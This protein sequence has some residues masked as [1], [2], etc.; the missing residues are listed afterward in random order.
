MRI[1]ILFLVDGDT[2][3]VSHCFAS[4]SNRGGYATPVPCFVKLG[5]FPLSGM[6]IY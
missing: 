6:Y 2:N 1:K 3:S 5:L 4:S